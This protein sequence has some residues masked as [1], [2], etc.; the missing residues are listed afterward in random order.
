MWN[1]IYQA[2][3]NFIGQYWAALIIFMSP[4]KTALL[5]ILFVVVLDLILGIIRSKKLKVKITSHKLRR[6]IIK[7][8]CYFIAVLASFVV[9]TFLFQAFDLTKIIVSLIGLVELKSIME[10]LDSIAGG[11]IWKTILEKLQGPSMK[12]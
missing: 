12:D 10:S 7:L 2:I 3:K 8:A 4:I 5:A 9:E 1:A 11:K 6:T